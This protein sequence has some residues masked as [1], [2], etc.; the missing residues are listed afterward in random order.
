MELTEQ[1]LT[2]LIE[3]TEAW[4]NKDSGQEIMFS[5]LDSM[6]TDKMPPE[7]K[8]EVERER[9]ERRRKAEADKKI[10]KERSI[11]LRAKLLQM[12][13]ALAAETLAAG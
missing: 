11:M 10:R 8:A 5:L 2:L 3:A 6:V 1:E 9:L 7:K 12:R 4:E 13:D